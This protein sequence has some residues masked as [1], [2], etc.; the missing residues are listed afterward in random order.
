MSSR[1]EI[2][3]LLIEQAGYP[4]HMVNQDSIAWHLKRSPW[5]S[6]EVVVRELNIWPR[7]EAC[8]RAIAERQRES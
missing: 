3:L 8:D 6:P 5:K 2:A 4:A 7:C 1:L